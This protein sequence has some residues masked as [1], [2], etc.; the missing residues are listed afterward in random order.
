MGGWVAGGRLYILGGGRES[1][2]ITPETESFVSQSGPQPGV[3]VSPPQRHSWAGHVAQLHEEKDIPRSP[4]VHDVMFVVAV[5]TDL[6]QGVSD[7][8]C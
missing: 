8:L 2:V 4:A 7:M 3:R 6:L 5:T 1:W